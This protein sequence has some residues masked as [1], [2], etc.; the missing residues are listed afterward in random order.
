[1][2]A[3]TLDATVGARAVALVAEEEE[4]LGRPIPHAVVFTMTRAIRSKQHAEIERSLKEQGVDV[5]EP[6]L[7]E[8]SA[9]SALFEF[10]GDLATL[11]AQGNMAAAQ[12]NAE[13]FAA[14]VFR[15]L[16]EAR[17]AA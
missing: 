3:T 15:R 14:A 11:P 7:M 10:G 16:T 13:G 4:A 9:F 17:E 2:R 8:R 5:V 1:M 12:A 6:G